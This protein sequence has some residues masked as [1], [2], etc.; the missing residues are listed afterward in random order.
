M[1]PYLR[2]RS[3]PVPAPQPSDPSP[4]MQPR[5]RAHISLTSAAQNHVVRNG[6]RPRLAVLMEHATQ[7]E[8]ILLAGDRVALSDATNLDLYVMRRRLVVDAR[9]STLEIVLDVAQSL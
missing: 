8:R 3:G 5:I 7:F 6:L 1:N 2:G 9:E 4:V